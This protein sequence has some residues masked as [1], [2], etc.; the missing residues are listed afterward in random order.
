MSEFIDPVWP[1]FVGPKIAKASL[2]SFRFVFIWNEYPWAALRSH[3]PHVC[4]ASWRDQRAPLTEGR[5][6]N[7]NTDPRDFKLWSMV[8]V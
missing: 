8:M 7:D 3:W 2:Y 1:Q 6:N 5:Q 4:E